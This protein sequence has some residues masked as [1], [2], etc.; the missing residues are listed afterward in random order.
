ML[1]RAVTAQRWIITFDR[2]YGNLIFARGLTAPPA[3][4]LFRLRSYRPDAP[5]W[6]LAGLIE[7]G[8]AFQGYFVLVDEAGFRKR[9]LPEKKSIRG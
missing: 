4:I 5:G 9:P 8:N 2:D 6:L 3:V 1:A 7:S